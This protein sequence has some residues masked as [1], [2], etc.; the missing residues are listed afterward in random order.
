MAKTRQQK[1]ESVQILTDKFSRSHSVVFAD[2]QGLTMKQLTDLRNKLR[3]E[4]AEFTV[5]K[6]TLSKLALKQANLSLPEEN[7]ESGP[8]ATLFSFGDE[9]SPLKILVKALK[10]AGLGKIKGGFLG[11]EFMEAFSL[12][13]LASLP[14]KQELQGQVVG[15]LVAP[16]SGIVN[17]LQGNLRNLVFALDQ[18]RISKGGE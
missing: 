15:L 7:I 9:I 13:R 10:D 1:E 11:T 12:N 18:I 16:L 2:Y 17:V 6:D 3:D 14:T 8:T 4:E 5:T